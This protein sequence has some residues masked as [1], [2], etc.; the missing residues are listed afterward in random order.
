L[1]RSADSILLGTASLL[2]GPTSY[3]ALTVTRRGF[4]LFALL[5][6]SLPLTNAMRRS[7]SQLICRFEA[8]AGS[9]AHQQDHADKHEQCHRRERVAHVTMQT[10]IK[11]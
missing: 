10:R 2:L 7:Q 6:S 3:E 1:T 8:S 9:G 4:S 5:T 11:G